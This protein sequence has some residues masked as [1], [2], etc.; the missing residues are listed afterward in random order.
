MLMPLTSAAFFRKV[1]VR[2]L[3]VP[4]V[5]ERRTY[6]FFK[7]PAAGITICR[8]PSLVP[9]LLAP[10]NGK[11]RV[12]VRK[13]PEEDPMSTVSPSVVGRNSRLKAMRAAAG[14][15]EGVIF[16]ERRSPAVTEI[17]FEVSLQVVLE[18]EIWHVRAVAES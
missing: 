7:V 10:S 1:K 9:P 8:T 13:D 6:S 14:V 4:G 16:M 18:S 12:P 15:P 2:A 3:S 17:E 5:A 11:Y